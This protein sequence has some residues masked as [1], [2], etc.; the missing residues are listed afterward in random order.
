MAVPLYL[1]VLINTE[2]IINHRCT[3]AVS[4]FSAA[5]RSFF[6]ASGVDTACRMCVFRIVCVRVCARV[7]GCIA[8]QTCMY[9]RNDCPVNKLDM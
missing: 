9:V 5:S 4:R 7:D 8:H 1:R 6:S 2:F 3:S